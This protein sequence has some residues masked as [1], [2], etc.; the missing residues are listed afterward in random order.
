MKTLKT[1]ALHGFLGRPTD[2]AALRLHC[3]HCPDLFSFA[4]LSLEQWTEAFHSKMQKEMPERDKILVGYSLGGRLGLH[5][6]IRDTAQWKGAIIISAH[7]GLASL[8]E[9]VLRLKKDLQWAHRFQQG[10]WEEVLREWNEQSVLATSGISLP[11]KEEEFGRKR[12]AQA[13]THWSLGRQVNLREAI[14]R[15]SL[16]ILW[17]VGERDLIYVKIA[18]ELF[19]SHP[20]SE[21]K[22]LPQAGHRAPWDQPVLFHTWVSAFVQKITKS[23]IAF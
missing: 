1:V 4:H 8:E 18:Q 20:D 7:P 23:G 17:I 19:F 14:H 16:P 10:A 5:A 11:R 9:R 15:L 22:I 13:L 6:L 21:V 12:L 2:W 3:D